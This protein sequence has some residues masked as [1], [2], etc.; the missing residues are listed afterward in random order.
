MQTV[1]GGRPGRWLSKATAGLLAALA[2]GAV[3]APGQAAQLLGTRPLTTE[4]SSPTDPAVTSAANGLVIAGYVSRTGTSGGID[5]AVRILERSATGTWGS[6]QTLGAPAP[7]GFSNEMHLASAPTGH[8]IAAWFDDRSMGS[9]VRYASRAPSG[10]WDAPSPPFPGDPPRLAMLPDG[11]ALLT[12]IV[13]PNIVRAVVI[14]ATGAATSPFD[15]FNGGAGATIDDLSVDA[16]HFA[17][18]FTVFALYHNGSGLHASVRRVDTATNVS[19]FVCGFTTGDYDPQITTGGTSPQFGFTADA[20]EDSVGGVVTILGITTNAGT[21]Q[22][23][24]EVVLGHCQASISGWQQKVF[25]GASDRQSVALTVRAGHALAVWSGATGVTVADRDLR[26]A[27]NDWV[28]SRPLPW[29]ALGAPNNPDAALETAFDG[30]GNSIVGVTVMRPAQHVFTTLHRP[31]RAGAAWVHDGNDV[32]HA[33]DLASAYTPG[34]ANALPGAFVAVFRNPLNDRYVRTTDIDIGPPTVTIS[35]LPARVVGGRPV[36]LRASAKDNWKGLAGGFTWH[37]GDGSPAATGA[38]V[39]HRFRKAGTLTVTASIRDVAGNVGTGAPRVLVAA[40]RVT[41]TRFRVVG[42][43]WRVSRVVGQVR[44]RFKAPAGAKLRLLV[45]KVGGRRLLLAKRVG[46]RARSVTAALPGRI[47]P[48]TYLISVAGTS[49]GAPTAGGARTL[50]IRA[51]ATGVVGDGWIT[52]TRHGQPRSVISGFQT[53][54]WAYIRFA[55]RPHGAV[56]VTWHGPAGESRSASGSYR[57]GPPLE[58]RYADSAGLS[59]GTWRAVVSV[60]GRT[61]ANLRIRIR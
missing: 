20:A 3:A 26:N 27:T 46:V 14:D 22:A 47:L 10:A 60:R 24:S 57:A 28:A 45:R 38:K 4:Q 33:D 40:P 50:R 52:A 11:R 42:L 55:V 53:T 35:G 9:G 37:F 39:T 29:A 56:T 59:H 7:D 2:L 36:T 48:G 61:V 34:L 8:A 49:G 54:L 15:V 18:R 13:F 31:N 30:L 17:D 43:G 41:I 51:P 25:T 58:F 6:V 32:Q 12:W 21:P 16:A 23:K 5:N 19:P 44:I 1:D